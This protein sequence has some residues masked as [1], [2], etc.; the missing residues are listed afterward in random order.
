MKKTLILLLVIVVV[1]ASAQVAYTGKPRY[2]I[3]VKRAGT[4]IGNIKVEL[5]PNIA[6]HHTRNFDSLVG[7]HFYD[8]V[9][10]HRVVPN[11]VIQ[12]G[13]PNSRHGDTLTWG[14]GQSGQPTVNAEFSVAKHKRG[15]LSAARLSNNIHSATSQFF[16]CITTLPNLDNNYSIY[17]RVTDGMNLVDT[18]VLAPRNPSDKPYKKHEMFI[19]AIGSNDTIPNAPTL[20]TPMDDSTAVDYNNFIVL[21]W[22]RVP[23]G[24]I[25]TVEVAYDSLFVSILKSADTPNL[26]YTFTEPMYQYSDY[27]WRVRVNNGG[28]YSPWSQV[29]HFDTNDPVPPVATGIKARPSIEKLNVYPN[30]GNGKFNFSGLKPGSTIQVFDLL[31]KQVAET[32]V[33]DSNTQINMENK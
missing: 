20:I 2:Q 4:L 18:I 16:I 26:S 22:N 9:A 11:F 19:T 21:N 10:F 6:Y 8:T 7:V 15:I 24:I 28:H 23:D 31:G 14:Q 32:I 30:P 33:K 29:W 27:Y 3:D 1:S 12:G 13:D 25:Y 17:G 5:F